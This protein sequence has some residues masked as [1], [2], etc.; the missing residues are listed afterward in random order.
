MAT[1]PKD[2]AARKLIGKFAR[3]L[4]ATT[5]LTV[6]SGGAAL[7]GTITYTEGSG[8]LPAD[9]SNTF[10]G[11]DALT[12]ATIPGT[13]NVNGSVSNLDFADFFELTGLGTGTFTASAVANEGGSPSITLFTDGDLSLGGPTSFIPGTPASFASQA[14]PSDGNLIIGIDANESTATYTVSVNTTG[15]STPEPGTIATVGLGLAG[16]LALSRRGRKQ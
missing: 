8:G 5:C 4:L 10:A 11:A 13:T 12:A 1:N 14:I 16:A 15:S 3:T 7:A 2:T 6:A 9:F